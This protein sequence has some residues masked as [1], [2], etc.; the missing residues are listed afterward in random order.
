MV[1]AM[2]PRL[3]VS[4][5]VGAAA[6]AAVGV[7]VAVTVLTATDVPEAAKPAVRPG[8]PPLLLDLGVR[9]DPEAKA[10]RSAEALYGRGSRK[11]AGLVFA[12]YGSLEGRVGAAL[13]A[14]PGGLQGIEQLASDNKKSGLVQLHLGLALYWVGRGKE[15]EAAWRRAKTLAPDSLYGIRADDLLHPNLPIPGRPQFVPSFA[16]PPE[17]Q[18]L[19]PPR[20]LAFLAARARARDAHAK[21]LYGVALQRLDRPLSA[22]RQFAAAAALAPNDPEAR[23]AAAVGLF[24]KDRPSL[25]FGRLGPLTTTFPLAPT[26]RFH[27]ALLLL[28]LDQLEQ[29]RKQFRLARAEAPASPLGR[30]AGAFL[31]RLET[32][33]PDGPT[34][35]TGPAAGVRP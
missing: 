6:L 1:A 17:L 5:L 30:E 25:A 11:A 31:A 33:A 35:P 4:F 8:A 14:W 24:D 32:V 29:A 26:V 34:G 2:S 13:A 22:E 3:R 7:T 10:L 23:A 15:A 28:W 27:L 12:R 21:L 16:S 18:R 20:Q 19:T 9:T